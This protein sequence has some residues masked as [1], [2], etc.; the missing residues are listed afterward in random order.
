[1]MFKCNKCARFHPNYCFNN[2]VQVEVIEYIQS[3]KMQLGNQ[4]RYIGFFLYKFSKFVSRITTRP[5]TD[6]TPTT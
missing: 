6:R 3:S 4:I 1:M 2:E 5:H